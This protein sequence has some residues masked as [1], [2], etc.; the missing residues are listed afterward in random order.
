[1][2]LCVMSKMCYLVQ[3]VS[4][5]IYDEGNIYGFADRNIT[6]MGLVRETHL[7]ACGKK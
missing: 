4:H 6:F 7:W 3:Q 2:H 1:M 5:P